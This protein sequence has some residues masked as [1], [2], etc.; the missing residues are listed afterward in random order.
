V[1]QAIKVIPSKQRKHGPRVKEHKIFDLPSEPGKK[2]PKSED[3]LPK[4]SSFSIDKKPFLG[5]AASESS[6]S[7][8]PKDIMEEDEEGESIKD[9]VLKKKQ[10]KKLEEQKKK[11][12]ELMR[13]CKQNYENNY[14]AKLKEKKQYRPSSAME[15]I[16][17]DK[18]K[19]EE[20]YSMYDKPEDDDLDD[21]FLE[22]IKEEDIED[23]EDKELLEKTKAIDKNLQSLIKQNASEKSS[24]SG[25]EFAKLLEEDDDEDEEEQD[26]LYDKF[27]QNQTLVKI[28][29][30]IK[31]LRHR[32][33]SALGYTLYEKAYKIIKRNE[34]QIREK[35][36]KLIGEENI[37]FFVVFDNILFL[38]KMKRKLMIK[39]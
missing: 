6:F 4:T 25:E 24:D 13:I 10:M 22:S 1:N 30:K 3:S 37:G 5:S 38:E 2:P 15:N 8:H 11:E 20:D 31:L 9:R 28:I 35:L 16:F 21:E 33:E 34:D 26:E 17:G 32:C 23:E 19:I 39:T 12:L 29:D 14:K 36:C 27:E 18:K 7:R